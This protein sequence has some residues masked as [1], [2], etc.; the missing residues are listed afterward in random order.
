METILTENL[1]S[2][3]S[4]LDGLEDFPSFI[5]KARTGD[6][7]AL[8][9]LNTLTL[10]L[11]KK[12]LWD[13]WPGP[14]TM[15]EI[16][17]AV[18]IELDFFQPKIR[19][20]A[21]QP[22]PTPQ[23]KTNTFQQ[24]GQILS[25]TNI[26]LSNTKNPHSKISGPD[27]NTFSASKLSNPGHPKWRD[28]AQ[29]ANFP[30]D[31]LTKTDK[32]ILSMMD[33]ILIWGHGWGKDDKKKGYQN[34]LPLIPSRLSKKGQRRTPRTYQRTIQHLLTLGLISLVETR[35]DRIGTFTP[36]WWQGVNSDSP[37]QVWIIAAQKQQ[38]L[39]HQMSNQC[40]T[41]VAPMSEQ[42]RTNVAPPAPDKST[43]I[44]S[45]TNKLRPAL[46]RHSPGR[47][48]SYVYEKTQ[49]LRFHPPLIE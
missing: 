29:A 23:P 31:R 47:L 45:K 13:C 18:R 32:E 40:R 4:E 41:D 9:Q 5:A 24:V 43:L 27:K 21:F 2:R 36:S 34:A 19:K 25:E 39:N 10:P 37:A 20:K 1:I 35:L 28:F 22:K 7:S 16:N 46:V 3:I 42:C 33:R 12:R 49:G 17:S 11:S 6:P 44:T 15:E 14:E 26:P 48:N 8:H 30:M 38:E